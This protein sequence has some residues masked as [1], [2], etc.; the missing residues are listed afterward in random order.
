VGAGN[1]EEKKNTVDPVMGYNVKFEELVWHEIAHI[2]SFPIVK[3]RS[4][5]SNPPMA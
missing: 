3:C 1:A 4:R 2:S 5:D